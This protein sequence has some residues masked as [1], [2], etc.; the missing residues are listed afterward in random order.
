MRAN[1]AAGPKNP[2]PI[3]G[4]ARRNM[5]TIARLSAFQRSWRRRRKPRS[6]DCGSCG[7]GFRSGRHRN[8]RIPPPTGRRDP[9]KPRSGEGGWRGPPA[10]HSPLIP[11]NAGTQMAKRH[12]TKRQ[13]VSQRPPF[14]PYDLGPGLAATRRPSGRRDERNWK[15]D[16]RRAPRARHAQPRS[17]DPARVKDRPSR[18][19]ARAA[20]SVLEARRGGWHHPVPPVAAWGPSCGGAK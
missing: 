11:A 14:Q 8:D 4:P 1:D 3:N 13:P 16:S 19:A 15:S 17:P 9:P 12:R 5:L 20:R 7:R 10:P 18:P 2:F 6:A